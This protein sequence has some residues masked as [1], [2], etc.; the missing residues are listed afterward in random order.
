MS[1]RAGYAAYGVR[2]LGLTATD[3]AERAPAP[4][5][6]DAW[7]VVQE[8]GGTP[9]DAPGMHVDAQGGRI[10]MPGAGEQVLDRA[11]RTITFR[12]REPVRPEAIVHPGLVPSAAVIGWW[13]G[14]LAVH[15][16]AIVV[17]GRVWGMLADREGGKSTTAA[18]LAERGLGLFADDMLIVAGDRCF[19]GPGSVDLRGESARVLGGE[20]LGVVGQRERWRKP[21]AP[22][23][24][25]AP[26]A[27]WVQLA[28]GADG[29][30]PTVTEAPVGTRIGALDHHVSLPITP[31]QL[32]DAALAP[33]LTLT[34]PHALER[35]GESADVLDAALRAA[36]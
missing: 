26:L 5:S 21:Y 1:D 29:D 27:G 14:R 20:P 7:T 24:L 18:L 9:D 36:A 10:G 22:T 11:A 34:R 23:L 16:S 32:L 31:D 15:A 6:W 17:D 35:A 25:E 2:F 19:A 33:M 3:G 28:W 4:A 13:A 30:D 12:T 8:T